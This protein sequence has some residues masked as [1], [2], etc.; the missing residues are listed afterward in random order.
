MRPGVLP[1][2]FVPLLAVGLTGGL[3]AEAAPPP[4][5]TCQVFPADNIWNTDISRLPVHPQSAQWLSSMAASTTNLHPD[6]G[7][8]PYGFPYNVVDNTHPTSSISFLYASESDPGPYPVGA[9]TSIESG[10]DHHALIVNKDTCT[11]YELFDLSGSGSTWS[12]G[13]GAI[14]PL[15]SDTLRPL[16]W[17]SAITPP[18]SPVQPWYRQFS[19]WAIVGVDSGYPFMSTAHPGNPCLASEYRATS[20]PGLY[21]NTGYD[22]LYTDTTH[23]TTSCKTQSASIAGSAAQQAAWAVGCSEAQD[24]YGYVTSKGINSAQAWWLDVETANSWCSPS[25]PNC[26]DLSL[27]QFAIQGIIDTF[28]HI[29]AVPVGIYSNNFLWRAI[30][31]NPPLPVTGVT[32]DW[33]ASGTSTAQQAKAFCNSSYSFSGNATLV[34][35]VQFV[36]N[37]STD[38]DYA[39]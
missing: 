16:G 14:F 34:R 39:C 4:S 9:D 25:G 12:A 35:I 19:T 18:G 37:S 27:N 15:N 29:G 32:M 20:S 10:S 7:A 23:T 38:S 30:L 8:P 21:V 24:D 36:P 33:Y 31:G 6:F 22:P 2:L 3:Q 11:L 1:L 13:S 28:N 17:T 5:T 26:T